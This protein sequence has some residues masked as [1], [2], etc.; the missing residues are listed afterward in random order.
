MIP[1][2]E[3]Q[4]AADNDAQDQINE[5]DSATTLADTETVEGN[6]DEELAADE[7]I[8]RREELLEETAV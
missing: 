1:T 4:R 2:L 5:Q 6:I 8:R 3:D 7:K